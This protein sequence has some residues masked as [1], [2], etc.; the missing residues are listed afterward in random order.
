MLHLQ[1][2][3]L[4][5]KIPNNI[6]GIKVCMLEAD[7]LELKYF[8]L[9]CWRL[10]AMSVP[11]TLPYRAYLLSSSRTVLILKYSTLY[12]TPTVYTADHPQWS[13]ILPVSQDSRL[14]RLPLTSHFLQAMITHTAHRPSRST[15]PPHTCN[16]DAE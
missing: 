2:I 6:I 15:I 11:A 3:G 9:A 14:V 5:S 16:G 4:G 13:Y 8:R 1:H 7:S 12:S 10:E